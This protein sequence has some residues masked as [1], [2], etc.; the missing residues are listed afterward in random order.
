MTWSGVV[1]DR[2]W[3]KKQSLCL[4]NNE[5]GQEFKIS[6]WP[7]SMWWFFACA[8]QNFQHMVLS[9]KRKEASLAV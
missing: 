5:K 3:W 2:V 6:K 1:K 9:K 8:I 7:D 4:S